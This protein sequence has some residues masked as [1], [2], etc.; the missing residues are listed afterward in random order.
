MTDNRFAGAPQQKYTERGEFFPACFTPL[1]HK[2]ANSSKKFSNNSSS[3]E[4]L[5][6]PQNIATLN[7]GNFENQHNIGHI[8][9][10]ELL[11]DGRPSILTTKSILSM[12][13][14]LIKFVS[15][16]FCNPKKYILSTSFKL[17]FNTST[18][19]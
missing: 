3:D 5:A 14:I 4:S 8:L 13:D 6:F 16:H 10:E 11:N 18:C 9:T 19:I 15:M 17:Y 1:K 7:G 2:D 12:L